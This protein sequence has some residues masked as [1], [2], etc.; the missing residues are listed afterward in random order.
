MMA[1]YIWQLKSTRNSVK[2]DIYYKPTN[3]HDYL[4]Y[5]SAHPDYTKNNIL[6]NLAKRILYLILTKLSSI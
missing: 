3:T 6:Y 1:F 2:T 5:D 4:P